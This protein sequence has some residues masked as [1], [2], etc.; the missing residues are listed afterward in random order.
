[1]LELQI[2][3]TRIKTEL[4]QRIPDAM[5]FKRPGFDD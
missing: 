1:V 4:E 3:L 5:S 2:R